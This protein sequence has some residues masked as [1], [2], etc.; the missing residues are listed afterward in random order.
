[1]YLWE[2]RKFQTN[3]SFFANLFDTFKNNKFSVEVYVHLAVGW[4]SFFWLWQ[5]IWQNCYN[6]EWE[7]KEKRFTENQLLPIRWQIGGRRGW[8]KS[9]RT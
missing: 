1:M 8:N 6:G 2:I 4:L 3:M 9:F 7:G 5:A